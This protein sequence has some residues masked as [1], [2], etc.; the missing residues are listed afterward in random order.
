MMSPYTDCPSLLWMPSLP[1]GPPELHIAPDFFHTVSHCLHHDSMTPLLFSLNLIRYKILADTEFVSGFI[2][3]QPSLF[4]F[5][6]LNKIL[7]H[8]LFPKKS[9][10]YT[11]LIPGVPCRERQG[12][13]S[14]FSSFSPRIEFL[15]IWVQYIFPAANCCAAREI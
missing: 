8:I 7:F 9:L 14:M 5:Y 11:D 4:S 13:T 1:S 3:S 6:Y 15:A 10:T 2:S 12:P